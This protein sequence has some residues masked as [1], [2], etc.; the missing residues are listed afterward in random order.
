VGT[1]VKSEAQIVLE[2]K[3]WARGKVTVAWLKVSKGAEDPDL[4]P[5]QLDKL[6]AELRGAMAIAEEWAVNYKA[7]VEDVEQ[8]ARR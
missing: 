3:A 2:R 8:R 7:V 5:E 4:T 6:E 1:P